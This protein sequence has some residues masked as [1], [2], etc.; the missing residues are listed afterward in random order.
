MHPFER[1]SPDPGPD[2]GVASYL[3]TQLKPGWRFDHDRLAIVSNVGN[4]IK[5]KRLLPQGVKVV[6]TAPW[7]STYDSQSLSED[8]SVLARSLQV[9]LPKADSSSSVDP[10][11]L[12]TELRH[13]DCVES[14][15]PG[16]RLELP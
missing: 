12:A 6:P 2:S 13:L 10:A 11:E 14:V 4:V 9:V 16:P 5:L 7:L 3:V 8:E 15:T 1:P